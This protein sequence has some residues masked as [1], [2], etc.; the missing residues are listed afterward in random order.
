MNY[1]T[2]DTETMG[3][4]EKLI[5]DIGFVIHDENGNLVYSDQFLI[6]EVFDDSEIMEKAFYKTNIPKYLKLLKE[7][8]TR[9]VS[10]I[11]AIQIL[12]N[13]CKTFNIDTIMAYNLLFD[14][15]ALYDTFNYSLFGYRKPRDENGEIIRKKKNKEKNQKSGFEFLKEF[16]IEKIIQKEVNFLCIYGYTVETI[17]VEKEYI[18]SAIKNNWITEK[19]NI[20]TGAEFAYRFITKNNDFIESHTAL[21]DAE[22]EVEIFKEC[23]HKNPKYNKEIINTPYRII[24]DRYKKLHKESE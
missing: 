20:Q 10:F 7:G 19:G 21:D 13:V 5:Y 15:G 3:I 4:D 2:F 1:L 12:V 24:M 16:L 14:L 8:K 23:F 22:I 6:K 18:D 11:E 17:M 9:K